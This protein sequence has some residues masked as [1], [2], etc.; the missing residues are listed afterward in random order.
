MSVD[1]ILDL[2]D[3]GLQRSDEPSYGTDHSPSRCARCQRHAPVDGGD[4]CDGC[5][6][7]LLEDTDEDPRQPIRGLSGDQAIYDECPA[8]TGYGALFR[9]M[10]GP[11]AQTGNTYLHRLEPG[12]AV[13]EVEGRVERI[14]GQVDGYTVSYDMTPVLRAREAILEPY[15]RAINLVT[16][17]LATIDVEPLRSALRGIAGDACIE[18]E[19][20]T[21]LNL[22]RHGLAATCPRHGPTRGGT[23]LKCARGRR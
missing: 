13:T 8:Y 3:G 22:R 19:P 23:C 15:T 4:F 6:A 10:L 7:F 11:V 18:P 9:H 5:R 14:V 1:T 2:I 12:G 20:D 16:R 21:T 17:A